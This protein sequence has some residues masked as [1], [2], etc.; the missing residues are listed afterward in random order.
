M[1]KKKQQEASE[2]LPEW[3]ATYGDLVTLLL[4]FF[5]LL[6]AMSSVDVN[7]YTAVAES[8][9]SNI[10]FIQGGGATGVNNML[11][12]GINNLPKVDKS[13]NDSKSERKKQEEAELNK[14]ASDFKTY[15]AENNV[16]ENVSVEVTDD[17]VKITFG[18]GILF[19]SGS[20]VLKN[21]SKSVLDLIAT[22][23]KDYS[24]ST[25]KF[26]GYTDNQ[27]INSA[28]YP[29][30][31]YLS[32][33]RSISVLNYFKDVHKMDPQYLSQEGFGEYRPVASNDTPEGRAK[34]RRV[35]IKIMS[36]Y[37]ESNSKF[38]EYSDTSSLSEQSLSQTTGSTTATG[39]GTTSEGATNNSN[40]TDN[41]NQI[42]TDQ[43][44]PKP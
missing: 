25:L 28:L 34:N 20:A 43:I 44:V 42:V 29:D 32:A 15:F 41:I 12:S 10:T 7:K 37:N 39:S 2:G 24:D 33:A 17:Y 26:E 31:M 14:M 9:N 30:N 8:F 13:V 38:D 35:E 21:D 23:L 36:Q 16:E 22:E 6:F 40:G 18:D 11:G 3:M 19:D 1:A 4:C 5:V 27:P